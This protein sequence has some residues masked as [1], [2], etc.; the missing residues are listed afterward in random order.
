MVLFERKRYS[1]SETCATRPSLGGV[2][3]LSNR[4]LAQRARLDDWFVTGRCFYPVTCIL[5][6][7]NQFHSAISFLRD[8]SLQSLVVMRGSPL[9]GTVSFYVREE[10]KYWTRKSPSS[11]HRSR[12]NAVQKINQNFPWKWNNISRVHL[13]WTPGGFTLN[14]Q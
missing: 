1:A 2:S 6:H 10:M 9:P 4:S 7:W 8:L 12:S 5:K 11:D 13:L 14:I 3:V